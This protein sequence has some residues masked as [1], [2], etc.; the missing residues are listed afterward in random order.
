MRSYLTLFFIS[1]ILTLFL[2]PQARRLALALGAVDVPDNDRRI[3][4]RPTPRMGGVAIYVAF[5]LTLLCVPLLRTGVSHSFTED[6]KWYGAIAAPATLIFWLGVYD[7]LRGANAWLKVAIQLVAAAMLHAFGFGIVSLAMPLGLELS[8]PYWLGFPL[9]ALWV[10]GITNAFNLID[11][12]DGLATGA[13]AFA[14]ISILF[15]SIAGDKSAVSL[16]SAILIGAVI[17]FLYYNFHPASIFLGDSGSLFLGFMVAALSLAGSQKGTTTI[18]IAIPLVSFG[19]PVLDVG[20]AIT[21]RFI[22]GHPLLQS[23]RGHIHHRLM[24]HGLSQRQTAI[25]LYGVCGAFTLFGILLLN[26]GRSLSA[27]VFSVIGVLV[28][29]G[30]QKLRYPEFEELGSAIR[31]R[32]ATHRRSLSVNVGVRNLHADL[33]RVTTPERLFALLS[34]ITIA[35]E[36]EGVKLALHKNI[37]P[38]RKYQLLQ[39]AESSGWRLPVGVNV[40]DQDGLT[41]MFERNGRFVEDMTSTDDYWRLTLPLSVE[42]HPFGTITFY[43]HVLDTDVA[44]DLRNLCSSFQRE[45]SAKLI[46]FLTEAEP[47]SLAYEVQP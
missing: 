22:K 42:G 16:T 46:S 5:L 45:L 29:L 17:G 14:L 44:V 36:F 26:P 41:L 7:D 23:D 39:S 43:R 35:T 6:L 19:L 38:R 11:G 2:T 47:A 9:T 20:L 30:V 13:S 12:I 40:E 34:E 24:D 1:L 21:R 25:L 3:H 18:A 15:F 28:I 8:I 32:V 33:Q 31:R 10:V 27:L 4:K 37:L